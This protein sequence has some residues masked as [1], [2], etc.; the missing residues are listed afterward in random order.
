MNTSDLIQ[1]RHLSRQAV[2]Y[3]RQSSPNQVVNNRESLHLQYGLKRRAIDLGWHER[4]VVVI[5]A[6]LGQTAATT[7]GREGFQQLVAQVAL[8]EIGILIAY[9]A[10][11]LARNCSHW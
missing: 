3:V 7:E 5:D 1:P 6:D 8:G 10:T 4:D 9:D 2:I 11:R